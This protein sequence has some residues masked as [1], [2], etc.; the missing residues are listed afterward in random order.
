MEQ[1][2]IEILEID[3]ENNSMIF[4]M[5]GIDT[6]IANS[7]RRILL[8][9]VPVIAI[10]D[11]C[12]LQNNS[13]IQDEVLCHRLGLIPIACDPRLFDEV[14]EEKSKYK[15][16]QDPSNTLIFKLHV[17]CKVNPLAKDKD[18]PHKRYINSLGKISV[19][20]LAP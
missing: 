11:C 7:L 5:I 12:V 2:K 14:N 1:F 15:D 16:G 13:I 17:E 9:E 20:I 18:P 19:V 3:E 6:A 10:E 8:A 4:D